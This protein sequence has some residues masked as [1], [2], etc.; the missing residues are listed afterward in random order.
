MAAGSYRVF[1]MFLHI[2]SDESHKSGQFE[3]NL[4]A[5]IIGH[6]ETMP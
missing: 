2:V 4:R 6:P 1:L 5:H 3:E